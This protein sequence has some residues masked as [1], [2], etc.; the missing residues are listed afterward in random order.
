MRVSKLALAV[1]V[2]ALAAARLGAAT[3]SFIRVPQNST[4]AAALTKIADGGTIE[5]A[6]GTYPSPPKG[7][8]ISNARKGFTVRAAAGATVV[9]DGGGSS[10]LWRFINSDRARGKRVTFE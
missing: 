10:N 5:I 7:F 1:A 2:L 6:A 8:S 4:L 9:I 3:N